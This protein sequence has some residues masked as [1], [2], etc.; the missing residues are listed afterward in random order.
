MSEYLEFLA[1]KAPKAQAAGIDPPPSLS[2][3]LFPFQRESVEYLL[4][5]GRGAAF[6]DTGLGKT[7]VQLE[8]A[9][10][11]GEHTGGA[12]IILCPLSVAAQTAREAARFGIEARVVR[13]GD[14]VG[15]R[16]IYIANYD[17]LHLF[18]D[19]IF[20]GVVLDE[21]SILKSF[22]GATKR[23]LVERFA[24]TP[25]RLACTATP[26]PNDYTE[27]GNH[28]AFLGVM[29]QNEMLSRWFVNDTASASQDWR[30]K[31]HAERDYWRWVASWAVC[32]S[33]PSDL[34]HDDAGYVL[35]E[36]R[37]IRDVVEVDIATDR[38]DALFRDLSLSATTVHQEKRRTSTDRAQFVADLVAREPDESWAIWCDTNYDADEIAR[39]IPQAVEVRGS[40]S[41]DEKE[42]ALEGFSTGAIKILVSKP[43]ICGFGLNW[44]HCS[45]IAFAS[46][47]FSFESLYQAVRRCWRFGQSRPVE[48]HLIMSSTESGIWSVLKRKIDQ[49]EAMKREMCREN[50][51]TESKVAGVRQAYTPRAVATLPNF[52]RRS[53]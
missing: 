16:G 24:E 25:F 47:S 2:P 40:D 17:R 46:V 38:G 42:R 49:H 8:W 35:P 5:L 36:L 50:F 27:L 11:V 33:K 12:V 32:A 26:A 45:R 13:S 31:K 51:K 39:L 4:R 53:N 1:R 20:A 43:S 44:Q 15:E 22:S 52:L 3:D 41:I 18:D 34:G 30:L 37:M 9:R 29:S 7:F 10:C 28:A 23:A 21:S 48:V 14:E 6:L 19:C